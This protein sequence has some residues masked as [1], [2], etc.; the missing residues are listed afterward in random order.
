VTLA[1]KLS[2]CIDRNDLHDRIPLL[3][4]LNGPAQN[5]MKG[6]CSVPPDAIVYV[7]A[8]ETLAKRSLVHL[9]IWGTRE[10]PARE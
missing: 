9:I 7:A 6:T 3:M 2:V 10:Q 4:N 5:V 8:L 1:A